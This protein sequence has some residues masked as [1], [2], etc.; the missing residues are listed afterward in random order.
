M[1][2]CIPAGTGGPDAALDTRL[3]RA[4]FLVVVDTESGE[5]AAIDNRQNV[6]AMQGAG[7]QTAQRIVE[8]GA[9]AVVAAHCGPKAF[10][11]LQ[12]V[13]LDVYQAAGG[14][15][16]ELVEQLKAGHLRK[17]DGANVQG[18]WS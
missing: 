8:T 11:V 4:A 13:G 1:K 2:V 16:A 6:D 5:C 18:R 17:L 9:E 14:T 3:G 10:A 15:V 12:A 7:I